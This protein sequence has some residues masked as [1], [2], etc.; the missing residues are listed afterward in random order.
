MSWFDT[1]SF[2]SLAKT[3]LK[4]AQ[5]KIDKV[6]DIQEDEL[7]G[8]ISAGL[9]GENA[10]DGS[11][12]GTITTEVT[13]NVKRF[14]GAA[15]RSE[16]ADDAKPSDTEQS[17]MQVSASSPDLSAETFLKEIEQKE[18]IT[19]P[20][21]VGE[22]TKEIEALAATASGLEKAT[23]VAVDM[24]DNKRP[25]VAST[26]ESVD[27]LSPP[28]I[29]PCSDE[30]TDI[31]ESVELIT[32]TS[33]MM[34][35][36]SE[37]VLP[38]T[39]TSDSIVIIGRSSDAGLENE[40]NVL[41]MENTNLDDSGN[42]DTKT[43]VESMEDT[44]QRTFTVMDSSTAS[45]KLL[46]SMEMVPYE[47]QTIDSDSTQSFED[48]QLHSPASGVNAT[49]SQLIKKISRSSKS[50]TSPPNS[51]DEMET[52]TSSD[53][54]IISNPNG[55]ASSTASTTT[56]TSPLK[57]D[58]KTENTNISLPPM[59]ANNSLLTSRKGHCREP[60]EISILSM[61]SQSED[62]IEK[63]LKRIS[64]LNSIVEARELRL[65]QSERQNAEL[66]DRNNELQALVNSN[67]LQS[68]EEYT[69]RVSSLEKKF[70]NCIRERD[71]LRT[72]VKDLEAKIPKSD[73]NDAL[74]ESQNM[75]LELRQE[76]E[77][78]AKEIL[79]QSNI[80]KKLRAK[81]KTSDNQLKSFKDQLSLTHEEVERLKKTLSAKEEVERTQIEAVHKM[82]SENQR[83]N[84]DNSQ[85]RSK[86][87][88]TQQKLNTLQR[89]FDAVKTELQQRSKQHSDLSR[90]AENVQAAEKEKALAK[91][92]NQE[93]QKQLL[94]LREKIKSTEQQAMKRDQQL[95]EENRQLMARLEAAE[96]RAESSTQEISQTTIPLMRHLESLQQTL[97]QR[98]TNWNKEEKLL[99]EK[100]DA[101]QTRL[102]SLETIEDSTNAKIELLKSRCQ[103]LEEKLSHA[104]MEEEKT[105]ISLQ[106]ELR[107][108]ETEYNRQISE[109][110]QELELSQVKIK[111]LEDSQLTLKDKLKEAE[112]KTMA[113]E[114][115]LHRE[116]SSHS[117]AELQHSP[118]ENPQRPHSPAVSAGVNSLEDGMGGSIDWHQDDLDCI[119]NSGRP[120]GIQGFGVHYLSQNTS[121]FE[122]LQS[123]LKQRDGEVAQTQWELSRLQAERNMLQ[124]ELSQLVM[125]MENLKEK[126]QSL[127][128]LEINYNDLQ[129]RYDALLQM[130]GEKVERCEELELDLK[131]C[132][133]AYKVQIQELLGKLKT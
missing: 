75:V 32:A 29:S 82:T 3:A 34:T 97:N 101:A 50:D 124:E 121:N 17:A 69:K 105:K 18:M 52:A 87:D 112:R 89:S 11:I 127:E 46:Q 20:P 12:A 13:G 94:E 24:P 70:Q 128:L 36:E 71:T 58:K 103:E 9:V 45:N 25:S 53:I 40:I 74:T 60:S 64:E 67:N 95:R 39:A 28:Q 51:N 130:Y 31:S 96:L 2:A 10:L 30:T 44:T 47:L 131:E 102:K 99:L 72:K 107:Q 68:S 123:M 125:E 108:K 56:R 55:D 26:L 8:S 77:K 16:S 41:E 111:S 93:L 22:V 14:P 54:E 57:D 48:V 6:L 98:T 63:L 61:D 113:A 104:V 106:L 126:L 90:T 133:E 7:D 88:D 117:L 76:G 4:E 132:K 79:Q 80:I 119:S 49:N 65:L 91:A 100:L 81:E 33:D 21:K 5:K 120:S 83:L 115:S 122:Y 73:L 78:L 116:Q 92:E 27:V 35:S 37:R 19:T 84:S 86:L 62:E 129:T 15:N 110:N 23:V 43:L 85:L 42:F 38:A 118:S 59:A 1:K 109:I 114:E 66:Q